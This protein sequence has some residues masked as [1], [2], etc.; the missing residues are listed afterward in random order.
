MKGL[1]TQL[2]ERAF[3]EIRERR[4]Y[5]LLGFK[6]LPMIDL[7]HLPE[8][9]KNTNTWLPVFGRLLDREMR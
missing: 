9:P 8:E 4:K 1:L 2:D 6:G 3:Q 7:G 5:V